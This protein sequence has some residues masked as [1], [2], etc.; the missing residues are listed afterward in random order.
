MLSSPENI[1]RQLSAAISII[2]RV[3]FY[4]KWQELLPEI[5]GHIASGDFTKINGC[6][7]TVHSIFKRYR[8][9]I[10]VFSYFIKIFN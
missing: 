2:G 8:Y 9:E 10:K 4:E 1:Q 3:D 6:L 5:V 7:R